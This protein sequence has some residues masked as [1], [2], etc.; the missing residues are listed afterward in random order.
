MFYRLLQPL[1][2]TSLILSVVIS[3]WNIQSDLLL[4]LDVSWFL[5][6]AK[7][8]LGGGTYSKDFFENNPPWIIYFSILPVLL[9]KLFSIKTTLSMKLFVFTLSFISLGFSN[10][11]LKNIF[12]GERLFFI[13]FL[14]IVVLATLFLIVPMRDFGQR[15]HLLF[16]LT[17]PYFLMMAQ[18][19]EGKPVPF[20]IAII[21]GLLAGCVFFVKAVFFVVIVFG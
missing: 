10:Y 19:L 1:F 12:C 3:A 5:E 8:L 9:G 17:M 4:N 6:A 14:L 20:F 13:R 7:R 18:H 15:E 21:V 2:L 16:I 11:F